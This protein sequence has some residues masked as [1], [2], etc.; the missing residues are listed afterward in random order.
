[1]RDADLGRRLE[2]LRARY[3]AAQ[4]DVM[5]EVVRA[6]LST[7]HGD[8]SAP[9]ASLLSEVEE[10]GRTIATAKAEIAALKVDDIT[11]SHIPSAT[12]ELDAIVAH[13]AAATDSI[14]EVCE[15]LDRVGEALAKDAGA[16][17]G[18]AAAAQLQD[19]TTRI[20]EAC[21]FQ[22]ITGQ[23][24]T[25]VVATLQAIE[26]KVAC[27]LATFGERG[28]GIERPAPAEEMLLN[29]PQLPANAMD[30]TDIDKLLASF[31]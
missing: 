24:I 12:D 14:L 4:P 21:S 6:V 27:M 11:A 9:Q 31:D 3:P 5:V 23:R 26:A 28:A 10:L 1:M 17:V 19:A 20:Y 2:E 18:A 13:T 22:D 30:Q 29:G 16:P 25:K 15:T 8:L 7:M